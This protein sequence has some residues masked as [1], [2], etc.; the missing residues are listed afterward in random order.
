VI[1]APA[2]DQV[3][4]MVM[5]RIALQCA[6]GACLGASQEMRSVVTPFVTGA[7]SLGT[8]GSRHGDC[9]SHQGKTDKM[10]GIHGNSSSE[11]Q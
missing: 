8:G 3:R 5:T 2:N 6:V 1:L 10:H 4:T 9:K 7:S 11:M